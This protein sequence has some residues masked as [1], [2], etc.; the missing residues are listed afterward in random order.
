MASDNTTR[1]GA[2]LVHD[3][4]KKLG[5]YCEIFGRPG[6]GLPALKNN[7]NIETHAMQLFFKIWKLKYP[8]GKR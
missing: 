1:A 2:E 6:S 8:G 3:R 4:C 5:I 7:T